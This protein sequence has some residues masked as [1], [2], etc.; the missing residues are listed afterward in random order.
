MARSRF[1]QSVPRRAWARVRRRILERDGYRC[2]QCGRPGRLEI[3]HIVPMARGGAM[4]AEDN[5]QTLC[6]R[7]HIE[8]HIREKDCDPERLAWREY[9]DA[10][11]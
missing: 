7:C 4:L 6:V 5:L 2:L 8:K 9:I 1:Q 11:Q 3:D 10:L